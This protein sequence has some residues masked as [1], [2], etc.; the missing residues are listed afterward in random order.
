MAMRLAAI[1]R[2]LP[3]ILEPMPIS[4]VH[5]TIQNRE[6]TGRGKK[7]FADKDIEFLFSFLAAF[8]L[9]VNTSSSQLLCETLGG[10]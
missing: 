4:A 10:N 8:F 6:T 9:P 1:G 3:K 7:A 2:G 5:S